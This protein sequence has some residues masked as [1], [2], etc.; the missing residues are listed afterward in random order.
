MLKNL[1]DFLR[2]FFPS[3]LLFSINNSAKF[4]VIC[5]DMG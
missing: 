1:S 3:T 4:F 2:P 5:E